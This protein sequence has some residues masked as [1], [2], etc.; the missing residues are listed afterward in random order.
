MTSFR[1]RTLVIVNVPILALAIGLLSACGGAGGGNHVIVPEGCGVTQADLQGTWVISHVIANLTCP[2]GSTLQTTAAA[3][4]FAPVTVARDEALPGFTITATGLAATVA[5]VSCHITWTYLD[6]DTNALF[7]CFTTFHPATRT[8]GGTVEA[9]HCDQVTLI[10]PSGTLGAS[11]VIPLPYLDA[12]VV[13]EG[14]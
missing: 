13:V 6:H 11:C 9:G 2:P 3:N 5:D 14:S 12:Y 10:N 1:R 4:S 8:A 7:E